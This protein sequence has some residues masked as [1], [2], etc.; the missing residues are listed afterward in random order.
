[1]SE[2]LAG[3]DKEFK[4][5]QGLVTDCLRRKGRIAIITGVAAS[6]K[7][8]LLHRLASYSGSFDIRFVMATGSRA[9]RALPFGIIRQL[10]RS[11]APVSGSAQGLA[12]LLEQGAFNDAF[13]DSDVDSVEPT[14]AQILNG[15]CAVLLSLSGDS[16]LVIA[17]DDVQ[18]ADMA[19]LQCLLYLARR[20][21]SLPVLLILTESSRAYP[22]FRAELLAQ[23]H[24][25]HLALH[26][27][28]VD[29]VSE[30]IARHREHQPDSP[31]P[32]AREYH[33]MAGGNPLLVRA[34]LED[35][36]TSGHPFGNQHT[37]TPV[38]GSAFEQA[39][40]RCV[41]RSAP[42]VLH[43][44][45][46]L[47][48]LSDSASTSVL[49]Q[50]LGV[51]AATVAQ[52]ICC[53]EE[54]GLVNGNGDF[55][56]PAGR[57]AVLKSVPPEERNALHRRAAQFL[58]LAGSE[59]IRV[60][61]HLVAADE[62]DEPWEHG[63]LEEAAEAA[64][65]DGK[66]EFAVKCLRLSYRASKEE[67]QR[68]NTKAL[69]TRAEWRVNPRMAS[70]HLPGLME[71]I[72]TGQV[73]GRSAASAI[74]YMVLHGKLNEA[75]TTLDYL[76]KNWD[77]LDWALELNL[78]M[79]WLVLAHPPLADRMP[80]L[81][82]ATGSVELPPAI[83]G[84]KLQAGRVLTEV[85]RGGTRFRQQN[86]R[87][88]AIANA[89]QILQ[90]SQLDD[91]TI[92]LTLT[93]LLALLYMDQA[94][95]AASWI[96]ALRNR[97]PTSI[98][99]SWQAIFSWVQAETSLRLG[100]LEAAESLG[101]AAL[102][103]MPPENW[104]II[105][106]GPLATL[107]QTALA[108]GKY[109]EAN[110]YLSRPVPDSMFQSIF[111]LLYLAARGRYDLSSNHADIA[112]SN[113]QV[114]GDLIAEWQVTSPAVV[115]WRTDAAQALIMLG[116]QHQAKELAEAQLQIAGHSYARTRAMSLRI[117]ALAS[118]PRQR[119]QMLR[120][121]V[122]LLQGTGDR[123][124]LAYAFT[125]LSATHHALGE[126]TRARLT[127]RRA[128]QLAQ[129]CKARPLFETLQ[130]T[131]YDGPA[132]SGPNL[133]TEGGSST[134]LSEAERRVAV[135]AA[136]GHTNR[137]IARKLYITVSTVEQHLTRIYRKLNVSQRSEL[138]VTL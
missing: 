82:V 13:A 22:R 3:R 112:L 88:K 46:A 89:N 15:L 132:S 9:E 38:P 43:V 28:S 76:G 77:D 2:Q 48:L 133:P 84:P 26:P 62:V 34:L 67:G 25:R 64:L 125:D 66:P 29:D 47:A 135:L 24:C 11:A 37:D 102:T 126:F 87:S 120:E 104:G 113:F 86:G 68:A 10:F 92:E 124:E 52:A 98:A 99:P 5:L 23:P 44:A 137:E 57:I 93:A 53:L 60:A 105:I 127:R 69:L 79:D 100:N 72:S 95:K 19:S 71:A 73:T 45:Q 80:T 111:G 18:D 97:A 109:D 116:D 30:M 94:D 110:A 114:C 40:L 39:A 96:E 101:Q 17:I 75:I 51:T 78:A 81:P 130:A 20:I 59:S 61:Q 118:D 70:R 35:N 108:L 128:Y 123:L 36:P 33:A 131:S 121:A 106:G 134:S 136:E 55:R 49:T 16:S 50:L 6:G 41:Y 129:E 7:S 54:T 31:Q 65:G 27:L 107:I 83:T 4:Y 91:R 56:H 8:E 21:Q 90:R 58:Y 74:K 14:A 117:L 103:E 1:M 32:I 115:T 42:E 85:M 122:D 63:V 119:G 12:L 138:P